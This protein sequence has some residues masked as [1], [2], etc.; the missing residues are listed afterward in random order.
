MP[1][2]GRARRWLVPGA[3]RVRL[4]ELQIL[5]IRWQRGRK[6]GGWGAHAGTGGRWPTRG[7]RQRPG[8][9]CL[10]CCL[11]YCLNCCLGC[12]VGSG[13]GRPVLGR[14]SDGDAGIRGGPAGRAGVAVLLTI[15][16][17]DPGKRCGC[18]RCL[19]GEGLRPAARRGER[20]EVLVERAGARRRGGVRKSSS[21]VGGRPW[22]SVVPVPVVPVAR[23]RHCHPGL[24]N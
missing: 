21:K 4:Q 1:G 2:D 10:N 18:C 19:V 23:H 6:P 17:C 16:V 20:R 11:N 15:W 24:V 8:D 12:C 3:G 22:R 13:G 5:Q 14:V 7:A 9:R